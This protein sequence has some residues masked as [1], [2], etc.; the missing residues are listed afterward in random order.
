M[1]L[2]CYTEILSYLD[3]Y[4]E[5]QAHYLWLILF[6]TPV[7]SEKTKSKPPKTKKANTFNMHIIFFWAGVK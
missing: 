7:L 3:F 4:T 6:I 1:V 5:L 2:C